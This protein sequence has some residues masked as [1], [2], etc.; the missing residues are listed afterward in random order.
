MTSLLTIELVRAM[1]RD[2]EREIR[3]RAQLAPAR[4]AKAPQRRAAWLRR[5]PRRRIRPAV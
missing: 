2:R 5:Y 1:M 3:R 4:R